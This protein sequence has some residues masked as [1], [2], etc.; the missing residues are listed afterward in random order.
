MRRVY[1]GVSGHEW[2]ITATV[3]THSYL[4]GRVKVVPGDSLQ[5]TMLRTGGHTGK[6]SRHDKKIEGMY[7]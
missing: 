6:S 3:S 1:L 7:S 4:D 5:P 2:A